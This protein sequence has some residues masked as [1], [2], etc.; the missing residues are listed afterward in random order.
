MITARSADAVTKVFADDELLPGTGSVV[1]E[2]TVATF[3]REPACA[4][5]VTTWKRARRRCA[6]G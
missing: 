4:G 5:A 1:A 6:G 2:V 3:V